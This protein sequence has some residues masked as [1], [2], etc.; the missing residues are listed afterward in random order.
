MLNLARGVNLHRPLLLEVDENGDGCWVKLDSVVNLLTSK[1]EPENTIVAV[2]TNNVK[3]EINEHK[4]GTKSMWGAGCV[5]YPS[6]LRYC[7]GLIT[8]I[9]LFSAIE[10]VNK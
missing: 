8:K 10:D 4:N 3:K 5:S 1:H 6:I 7:T 9:S 2:R